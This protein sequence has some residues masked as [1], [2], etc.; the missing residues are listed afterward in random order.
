MCVWSEMAFAAGLR[1]DEQSVSVVRF[2]ARTW[3]HVVRQVQTREICVLFS[4]F[5][6]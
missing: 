3:L 2:G 5:C 1:G 6:A 4:V